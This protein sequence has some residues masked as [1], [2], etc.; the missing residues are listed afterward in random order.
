MHA[1]R[2]YIFAKAYTRCSAVWLRQLTY[3][4]MHSDARNSKHANWANLH[5]I[6]HPPPARPMCTPLMVVLSDLAEWIM[7]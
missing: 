4:L 5:G 2:T 6:L 1:F 3:L 7:W